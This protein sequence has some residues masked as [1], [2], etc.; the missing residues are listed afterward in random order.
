MSAVGDLRLRG[1]RVDRG[2]R[3]TAAWARWVRP[4]ALAAWSFLTLGIA[5]G[6]WWAYYELGWGGWWF[7]DPVEN[8]S[9]MPWLAA[10]ALLH[11]STVCEKRDALKSWTVLL[12]IVAFSFSLL[13]TFLVRSGAVVSVH[14]FASD[15]ERGVFIL[16]F[17]T[18]AVGGSPRA[19]RGPGPAAAGPAGLF[20]P[21]SREGGLV[22]NNLFLATAAA[23]V[24]LGTLYPLAVDAFGADK[25]SVGAPWFN[26]VFIPLAAPLVLL[27]GAGPLLSWK[28]A[29]AAGVLSRLKFAAAAAAA[30]GVTALVAGGEGSALGALGVALAAWLAAA[31][32][33][34]WAGRVRL[35]R[36]GFGESLRRA[37]QLPRAAWG[38]S[39]AHLGVAIV[40]AGIAASSAW[41]SESYSVMRPGDSVTVAGYDFAF[42]GVT[43]VEGP[44]Y[45]AERGRFEV[46]RGGR[47]V[48][49]LFPEKR[50]YPVSGTPTTEAAIPHHLAFR[51]L[52]VLGDADGEG[53]WSTRI[54][55][56]P[57]VPWIW[58]G[59]VTMA[60]GGALSLSD[61]RHRVGAPRRVRE[62]AAG[63]RP[64]AY[65]LPVAGFAVV[66]ALLAFGPRQRPGGAAKR[67]DGQPGA[68]LRALPALDERTRGL[69]DGDLKPGEVS[70]VN[71]FASWCLPC[72]AEHPF[73][74]EIAALDGVSLYGIAY[75]DAPA[76]TRGFLDELGDPFA[77]I[78]AD[79]EGRAGIEFGISGV[80]ET[81]FI[82][83]DGV[84]RLQACGAHRRRPHGAPHPPV[85]R[86][87]DGR[88]VVTGAR[89]VSGFAPQTVDRGAEAAQRAFET[90]AVVALA[91]PPRHGA[92]RRRGR[93][94]AR[95]RRGRRGRC[96][97][98]GSR[99][100]RPA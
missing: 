68:G 28:R 89:G 40:V 64:L 94:R 99:S 84:V 50:V 20:A 44:N 30:A 19:L 13:G 17:L 29:D 37:A 78:G 65:I 100:R 5:L 45:A 24:L 98:R 23:T 82:G 92:R 1:R 36:V 26:A 81:V 35:G 96:S 58:L 49:G 33:G 90:E 74:V 53:G 27:A 75:K 9:F 87:A 59:A 10:T 18:I 79:P 48:A 91:R 42:H 77:R 43:Q 56:N 52:R 32:C 31:T 3:S 14:A 71:L 76:D 93:P 46:T 15:P 7:W 57:L 62:A 80:P 34:E 86:P 97:R 54:Y 61:R 16:A 38:M 95:P 63:M 25:V 2:P 69:S 83:P 72:R 70:V 8:A 39:V 73:L 12:A 41:R 88:R 47:A 67:V 21:V 55:H 60:L 51:S 22:L 11:S 4:W 85:D 66:A 6:S